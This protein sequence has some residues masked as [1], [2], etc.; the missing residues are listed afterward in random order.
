MLN[1]E[2]FKRFLFLV[3]PSNTPLKHGE[4]KSIIRLKKTAFVNAALFAV[5]FAGQIESQQILSKFGVNQLT[6]EMSNG[7][8]TFLN[9]RCP[10]CGHHYCKVA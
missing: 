7:N 10:R 2:T 4:N 6:P 8:V 1:P 9:A 3:S 5:K